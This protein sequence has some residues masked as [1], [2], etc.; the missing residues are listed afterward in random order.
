MK[1]LSAGLIFVN[2][3]TVCGLLL[4]MA[5]NG[6]NERSAIF[7]LVSGAAFAVAA[8]LGTSDTAVQQKN[9][10]SPVVEQ[11]RSKSGRQRRESVAH[12][13]TS[14]PARRYCHLWLWLMAAGFAV[15]A[16]RAFCWLLYID[17]EQLKIQSPN[18]LGD[19]ALH[20]TFIRNF[21]SGVTL[22]PD[23]PIYVFSKLRYPVGI[24][25]FNA[26]LC[27]VHV[28]LMRGLV[29]TGLLASLA[30]FYAFFRWA[31]AFGVAGFL[32][33]G[34]IAGFQF[35]RTLK[36][37]DYQGDRTIAWKS[38]ALSMFVTQRG[39][40]YAIPAGLLLLW[41]WREKFFREGT[42]A[43]VVDP[44]RAAAV[45]AR[46]YS[47]LPFWV[48]FFLYASMPL[49][50]VHTFLALTIVLIFL[51]IFE[52]PSELKF[53]VRVA[54]SE[55][56]T[57]IGHLI[58]RPA[59]WPEI[60]R[61][62]PIRRHAGTVLAAALLPATF[63]V[64]L[65]TD[66]FHAASM[67]QWHPG[68]VQDSGD[69]AAPFFRIGP[70]NFSTSSPFFG[71]VL[72]KTW[73]GVIAPAFQF[74]LTNFGVWAPL[75]LALIGLCGWRAWKAGWRWGNKPPEDIAFLLPA[76]A[77]FIFGFLVKTTPWDW[78][79]LKLIIWAYFL[80]LPFLWIDLIARWSIF[81]RVGVCVALFGSGFVTLLGGLAA[82]RAGWGLADRAEL[83][84]VGDAL[85]RLPLEARFAAYPT[86]NHPLLLQGRKV[87]LGYP[88]HLWSQ[89]FDYTNT[90]N[91]LT[92]LMQGSDNWREIAR[93]LR[94]RYIFWGREETI[95][96][97][98]S[99]QPWKTTVPLV[100]SG[101]WG[102][103]YDLE[104]TPLPH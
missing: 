101:P 26:L 29:W 24:D 37:L 44:G 25:L 74:W 40:L 23:N 42:V 100:A 83:D 54:R 62:A 16:V 15:F 36:F 35:F 5:G 8:Y 64:W 41:H 27:L 86:Y 70:V 47:P 7:A 80:V 65:T 71:W 10:N 94:I 67:L 4:G 49:F 69:F 17:G 14:P 55:G 97:P 92:K 93:A 63:F 2:L 66:H 39:L 56:S 81:V 18:N 20:I 60:F 77:I 1:W 22:W 104:A 50:H 6:L 31:G 98:A 57:G 43:V 76:I 79:N 48:E 13:G 21:A 82:N 19:L 68:W 28:D 58:S 85:Q 88:G 12:E 51:F 46:G 90:Y 61:D 52:G 91:L 9:V 99:K 75:I 95:N 53:I 84:A 89:G 32:F 96:Y 34:G 30:T 59:M 38:I 87:A 3:S 45:N 102:A 11:K 103:I 33:N 73:N 78:D 72:Q